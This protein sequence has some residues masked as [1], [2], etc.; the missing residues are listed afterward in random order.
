MPR[1]YD[2][3]S[4]SSLYFSMPSSISKAERRS[5]LFNLYAGNLALLTNDAF[6][7][8]F[9]CP[10]CEDAFDRRALDGPNLLVNLAHV[11]PQA[12]GATIETLTCAKCNNRMGHEYDH[13][14]TSEHRA[15]EAV[16]WRRADT[17]ETD[18]RGWQRTCRLVSR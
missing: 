6:P 5:R 9:A 1:L 7:G 18:V 16:K 8:R 17:G 13:H 3:G 2:S 12:T 11:Y 10:I 15:H 14:L 4:V